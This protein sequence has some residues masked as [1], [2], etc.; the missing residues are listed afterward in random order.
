MVLY[1][2]NDTVINRTGLGMTANGGT[3]NDTLSAAH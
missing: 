3:G 1:D 2:R